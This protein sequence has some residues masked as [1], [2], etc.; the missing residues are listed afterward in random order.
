MQ[1]ITMCSLVHFILF[2]S[3]LQ[4]TASMDA[5]SVSVSCSEL[6][7]CA[8]AVSS[9]STSSAQCLRRLQDLIAASERGVPKVGEYGRVLVQQALAQVSAQ[10]CLW[11]LA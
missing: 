6:D 2:P 9:L 5:S 8:S 10:V 1:P 11:V 7:V 3:V 4:P